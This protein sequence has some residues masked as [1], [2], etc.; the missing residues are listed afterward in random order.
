[1]SVSEFLLS[2]ICTN[3]CRIFAI[4]PFAG[5]RLL[6]SHLCYYILT[7][8]TLHLPSFPPLTI[9]T[10]CVTLISYYLICGHAQYHSAACPM[11]IRYEANLSTS[12]CNRSRSYTS[13]VEALCEDCALLRGSEVLRFN[14]DDD[15]MI[16]MNSVYLASLHREPK[17]YDQAIDDSVNI[18]ISADKKKR[19]IV[20]RTARTHWGGIFDQRKYNTS[21]RVACPTPMDIF[22]QDKEPRTGSGTPSGKVR[23]GHFGAKLING[24]TRMLAIDDE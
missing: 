13:L 17:P 24:V 18:V 22:C 15:P 5:S 1:M 23:H 6:L 2:L 3:D 19:T 16:W 21:K 11:A 9:A 20:K 4:V 7:E 14:N 12:W 10:M 8:S